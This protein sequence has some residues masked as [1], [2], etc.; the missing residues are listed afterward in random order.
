MKTSLQ[1]IANQLN[2]SRIT[3]SKVLNNK[4]GVSLDTKRKVVQKLLEQGYKVIDS[5]LMDLVSEKSES[6]TNP[7]IAVVA[8]APEFSEFWLKIIRSITDSLSKLKYECIYSFLSNKDKDA[9]PYTLPKILESG[10]IG[11]IIVINVYEENIIRV[12]SESGIPNVFLDVCPKMHSEGVNGDLVLLDGYRAIT[13]IT[14]RIIAQGRRE[15]GFI[16][17]ITYSKTILDRW[18]G[19]KNALKMN[20][21]ELN[22]SYCFTHSSY[23][24]YYFKE[25]IERQ[26]SEAP[27]L[28]QAFICAN[29]F[30]AFM[31]IDILK[32]K[33]YRVPEDI[34]VSGFDDIREKLTEESELTTV[35]I[36][37]QMLGQRLVQQILMKVETPEKPNEIVYIEPKV[38]FRKSTDFAASDA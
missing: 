12:L 34:A 2:I 7:C 26:L 11:G 6:E 35:T 27:A 25:E 10:N 36:D 13:E 19:Y 28:P 30:I 20:H 15:I 22:T 16:G 18:S 5:S 33:N 38:I 31:L 8:T 23:G 17:D 24:H 3:V 29:D 9:S 37:T 32:K 21:I 14:S 1:E 4:P